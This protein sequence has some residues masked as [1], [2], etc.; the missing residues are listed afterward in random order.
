MP[1]CHRPQ[2]YL[3]VTSNSILSFYK[4]WFSPFNCDRHQWQLV[5]CRVFLRMDLVGFM[6]SSVKSSATVTRARGTFS[7]YHVH[8]RP[9]SLHVTVA[10]GAAWV[11][12]WILIWNW[13]RR[14][15]PLYGTDWHRPFGLNLKSVI[16]RIK[17]KVDVSGEIVFNGTWARFGPYRRPAVPRRPLRQVRMAMELLT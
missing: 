10:F 2:E 9:L 11:T 12:S 15:T 14:L 1:W 4:P 3:T 7:I 17:D 6:S 16:S 13:F 8:S 5:E